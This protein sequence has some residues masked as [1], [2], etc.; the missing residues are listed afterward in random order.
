LQNLVVDPEM[1]RLGVA[2][3]LIAATTGFLE[4]K[5]VN[6]ELAPWPEGF[7]NN[8]YGAWFHYNKGTPRNIQLRLEVHQDNHAAM[9]LYLKEGFSFE[10]RNFFTA[11]VP[12]GSGENKVMKKMLKCG[13]ESV[14]RNPAI[15]PGEDSQAPQPSMISMLGRDIF[16]AKKCTVPN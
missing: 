3:A 7:L 5:T 4:G 11:W 1:R 15:I 10:P 8:S 13:Q 2:T 6:Q 16:A 14:Q 9:N 12:F